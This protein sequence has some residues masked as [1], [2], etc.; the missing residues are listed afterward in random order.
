MSH[1]SPGLYQLATALASP[2]AA[3]DTLQTSSLWPE[4]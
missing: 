1:A 4:N 3:A 2:A